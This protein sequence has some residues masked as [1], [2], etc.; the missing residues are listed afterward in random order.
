MFPYFL[1]WEYCKISDCLSPLCGLLLIYS[2]NRVIV[3]TWVSIRACVSASI[4]IGVSKTFW[5]EPDRTYNIAS[6]ALWCLA[7]MSAGILIYCIPSAPAAVGRLKK[8][9]TS[10]SRSR[11]GYS[12]GEG[13]SKDRQMG[14]SWRDGKKSSAP[15]QNPGPY[16]EIDEVPLTTLSRTN[17]VASRQSPVEGNGD[18]YDGKGIT[19]TTQVTATFTRNSQEGTDDYIRQH[20]WASASERV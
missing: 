18:S 11:S 2:K 5:L 7:E 20:P 17:A 9:V 14:G 12:T 4:R 3:L 10:V 8:K 1:H 15:K 16:E 19:R 13:A 6:T